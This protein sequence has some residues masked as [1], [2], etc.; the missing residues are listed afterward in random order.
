MYFVGQGRRPFISGYHVELGSG[1]RRER[2]RE[3][4]GERR[5]KK[6]AKPNAPCR[7]S[8]MAF[9]A[10]LASVRAGSLPV[11]VRELGTRLTVYGV[12]VC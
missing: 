4:G 1:T 10:S 7:D 8:C 2:G 12:R 9:L 3:R 11:R 5:K 6:W